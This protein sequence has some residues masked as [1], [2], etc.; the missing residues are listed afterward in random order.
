MELTLL[1]KQ[2]LESGRMRISAPQSEADLRRATSDFYYAMFHRI[3]EALVEPLLKDEP[4]PAFKDT[5]CTLY[6]L[7]EHAL[8][9]R[10]CKEVQSHDF[11]I[12]IK[13][14]AQHVVALK[15]KRQIADYDPLERFVISDVRN[16]LEIAERAILNFDRAAPQERARFAFF[17]ALEAKRQKPA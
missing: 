8:L 17:V 6:R 12:A 4:D 1:S 14:F 11:S 10:R 16:D 2:I 9:E 13:R 5:Y 7:P 15:N 3:C